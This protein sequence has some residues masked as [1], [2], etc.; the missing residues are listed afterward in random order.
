MFLPATTDMILH[1]W[2]QK[3]I[4]SFLHPIQTQKRSHFQILIVALIPGNRCILLHSEYKYHQVCL[5]ERCVR[6]D[7]HRQ[8]GIR[9]T[10]GHSSTRLKAIFLSTSSPIPINDAMKIQSGTVGIS[11]FSDENDIAVDCISESV[12]G[13]E[14]HR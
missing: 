6:S 12:S 1:S 10:N 9:A 13:I 11:S 2:P 4:D 7:P 8:T 3:R 5:I 14:M